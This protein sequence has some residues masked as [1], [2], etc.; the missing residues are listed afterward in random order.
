MLPIWP[1]RLSRI[2]WQSFWLAVVLYD[3]V[4]IQILEKNKIPSLNEV[5]FMIRS[6]EHR[7]I[8]MLDEILKD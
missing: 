3:Q 5:F 8:A 6:K 4:I 7:Q 1:P 2:E